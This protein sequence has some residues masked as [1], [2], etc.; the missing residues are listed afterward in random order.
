[1]YFSEG[2]IRE[3]VGNLKAGKA[4]GID[5]L[6]NEF[7][8]NGNIDSLIFLL[9]LF[10]D[11][12]GSTGFLPSEFNTAIIIPIPKSDK[13]TKPVDYRPISLSTPL[14][15]IF[16]CIMLEKLACLRNISPNQFGYRKKT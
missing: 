1:M 9:K 5:N 13:L 16:E 14:T 2:K 12:M 7:F 8:K 6:T 11:S 10:F 3:A 4:A 15:T